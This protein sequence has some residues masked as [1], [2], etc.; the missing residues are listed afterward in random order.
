MIYIDEL[1]LLILVPTLILS[2]W[3]QIKVKTTFARYSKIQNSRGITGAQMASYIMKTNGIDD[4][5]IGHIS[6]NLTDHYSPTRKELRLSNPVY[7]VNSVAA[8]G[9]AAHES[10]HAIQHKKKYFPL[11]LRSTLVPMANIGSA[12]GPTLTIIGIIFSF[13]VLI[14]LGILLFGAAVAFY[15]ITL[16]VEIN[17]SSRAVKLLRASNLFGEEELQGV[18]KVLTAAA[19][20]YVASA[21]TAIANLLRLVLLSKRRD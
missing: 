20:T 10:G 7:G 3:A 12:F 6:G 1:Y 13:G 2:I 15:L 8:I 21:L 9:V 19:L 5:S 4:V 14:D 18:K 16:P 17:A 11:I